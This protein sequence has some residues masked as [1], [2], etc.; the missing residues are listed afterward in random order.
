MHNKTQDMPSLIYKG[1]FFIALLS[2]A[3]L[4]LSGCKKTTQQVQRN[5][6]QEYFDANVINKDIVVH[7]ATDNGNDLTAQ[8]NGYVF[9]LIKNTYL[10]GPLQATIG[11]VT[12]TGTWAC[13]DDYGKLTIHLPAVP[14]PFVFLTREW[15]FTKKT[16]PIM[17]LAPWGTTDPI[18]L[19]MQRL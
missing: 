8:Y 2:A 10:D 7:L 19:H 1:R 16:V 4:L 11:G 17:E 12:Y 14:S 6:A 15:R 3:L 9:K 5:L 13:N 18:V